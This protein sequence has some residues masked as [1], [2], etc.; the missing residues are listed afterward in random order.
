MIYSY[1]IFLPY[2]SCESFFRLY[3][4]KN[5]NKSRHFP[6]ITEKQRCLKTVASAYWTA[7]ISCGKRGGISLQKN[8]ASGSFRKRYSLFLN[9][10]FSIIWSYFLETASNSSS[11]GAT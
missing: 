6:C 10:I 2:I 8:T 11:V 4:L 7:A 3:D 5:V 9:Y 1:Y